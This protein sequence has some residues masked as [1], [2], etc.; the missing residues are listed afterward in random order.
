MPAWLSLAVLLAITG[1]AHKKPV[2][3]VPSEQPP[4]SAP[5]AAQPTPSPAAQEP[6]NPQQGEQTAEAQHSPTPASDPTK[7]RVHPGTHT[8]GKKPSPGEKSGNR[9][10]E[11]ADARQPAST[12]TP[13][14]ISPSL[15]PADAAR[16]QTS[17]EQLLQSTENNLNSIKRQLSG[18]EQ[19]MIAQVRNFVVQSRQA[20]KDNEP[21]RARNLAVKANLLSN[22]LVKQR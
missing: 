8:G 7:K 5:I 17:T 1:C 12:S 6:S 20:L 11:V 15:S 18:D 16:D 13:L 2:L 22:D 3:V 10:G 21:I 9:N 4:A 19:N 14:P